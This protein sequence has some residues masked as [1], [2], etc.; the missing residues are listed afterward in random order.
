M[1]LT[2]FLIAFSIVMMMLSLIS[3]RAANFLKIHFQGK[4]IIIPYIYWEDPE[5]DEKKKEDGKKKL[6][7]YLSARLRIL[8]YTQPTETM[9]KEREYRIQV[10][11]IFIGI[12]IAAFANANFFEIIANIK[13][14]NANMSIVGWDINDLKVQHFLGFL[15]LI[16]FIWSVSLMLFNR[17]QENEEKVAQRVVRYPFIIWSFLSAILLLIPQIWN[18]KWAEEC[19]KIVMH[20]IGYIFTGLFLSLGSKFW[21][22][23]LDILFKFKNTKQ[24]LSDPQ[25]YNDY[26]SAD[27]LV[28]LSETS[29]Y[30]VA[31]KL[32][33]AYEK[34]ISEIAGVVSYGLSTIL[35]ERTKLYRKIIEVEF[36]TPEAQQ[37]LMALQN[38]G[39]V[40]VNLNTFYLKDHMV[41]LMTSGI[42]ALAGGDIDADPKC[43]AYNALS[44]ENK[45]S[46][47]V[48]KDATGYY[49]KSNLHVFADANEFVNF[50]NNENYKLQ[51]LTVK[52]V[53]GNEDPY[54]GMIIPGKYKLGYHKG[55]DVDRC[56]CSIGQNAFNAYNMLIDQKK[57]KP[58][59]ESRMRM[60]GA[61]SKY[62]DF[63]PYKNLTNCIMSY[64]GFDK[65]MKLYKIGTYNIINV[66]KGDSGA[67]V[68]YKIKI[69]DT[70]EYINTGVIVGMS[71][72]YAY[73]FLDTVE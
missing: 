31:R 35:D 42:N 5:K 3:E 60:F 13:E 38:S 12:L 19:P 70:E 14:G 15:Y 49:A 68:Y 1:D 63:H 16:I 10:I 11:N 41:V 18:D 50:G 67:L 72:N 43:Y 56:I 2:E 46:F 73:M 40:V 66:S 25:T 21:H 69:S 37:K 65:P 30:E 59:D 57:L 28:A 61:V 4:K 64:T 23:L 52:F 27:K 53:I 32:Y 7:F 58:I 8:A 22:D 24:A 34:K 44:P 71:D 20:M 17:L 47:S 45:G 62:T 29:Q 54:V 6:K 39:S 51:N 26:D 48:F 55:N 36:T 33:E 9:E